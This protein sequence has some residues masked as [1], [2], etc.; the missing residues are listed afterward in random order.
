MVRVKHYTKLFNFY[1]WTWLNCVW[2]NVHCW[3]LLACGLSTVGVHFC[4]HHVGVWHLQW[5]WLSRGCLC[6]DVPLFKASPWL[7][8]KGQLKLH[9][10]KSRAGREWNLLFS[11]SLVVPGFSWCWTLLQIDREANLNRAFLI[12]HAASVEPCKSWQI[13]VLIF[14][15]QNS[16]WPPRTSFPPASLH[17]DGGKNQAVPF[18][19]TGYD[20]TQIQ[21]WHLPG[22]RDE[23][24]SK[25]HIDYIINSVLMQRRRSSITWAVNYSIIKTIN[26]EFNLISFLLSIKS[27]CHMK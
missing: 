13:T 2:D 20:G 23:Q 21:R 19:L 17:A 8:W 1:L 14:R 7:D 4:H 18:E 12:R 25:I 10:K 22:H 6:L 16:L 27:Y 24:R 5:I 9:Y 11:D 26:I 3:K 15:G